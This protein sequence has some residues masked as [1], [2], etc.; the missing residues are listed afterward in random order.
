MATKSGWKTSEFW[1]TIVFV[2][3]QLAAVGVG[4]ITDPTIS[5]ICIAVL[6]A[7]YTVARGIAKVF[8]QTVPDL[9]IPEPVKKNPTE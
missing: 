4:M 9:T 5:A 1:I 2:I 8:G 7:A 6:G 3:L